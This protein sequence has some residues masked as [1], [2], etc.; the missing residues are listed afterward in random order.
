MSGALPFNFGSETWP[1]LSKLVEELGELQQ[2][3]GKIMAVGGEA[4]HYDGSDLRQRFLE[5]AGDV[6][7]SLRFVL[8]EEGFRPIDVEPRARSKAE[9][10]NKW[11]REAKGT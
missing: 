5:E 7:A 11:H 1:G 3:L 4:E 2:V 8:R 6:L 10:F 9:L